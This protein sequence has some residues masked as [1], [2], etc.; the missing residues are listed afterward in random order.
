MIEEITAGW[1]KD[2]KYKETNQQRTFFKRVSSIGKQE[3]RAL[4]LYMIEQMVHLGYRTPTI[5][6]HT[7]DD[8]TCTTR[9]EWVEGTML[10]AALATMSHAQVY[11]LGLDAGMF[12][13]ALHQ[14]PVI[15]PHLE[16]KQTYSKKMAA[17]IDTYHAS[18]LKYEYD[19]FL[20]NTV[21]AFQHLIET[22]PVTYHHGDYHVGNMMYD[23]SGS[24]V[25]IDFDRCDT[26]DP[27]EEFNRIVWSVQAH[28][29]FASGIV[30][31]YFDAKPPHD[32]WCLLKLYISVNTL[33]SLPWAIPYGSEE[34]KTMK[35]QY[36]QVLEWYSDQ[37]TPIPSWY[38]TQ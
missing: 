13:K 15:H 32:F 7:S 38:Q 21:S 35:A 22:R 19:D 10:E 31:G 24:L 26:G 2:K 37:T 14:I 17:K 29:S 34:I 27:Y 1:S 20:F 12:L 23:T 36:A 30:D 11:Q 25:V 8:T 28:P 3:T 5:V 4:E 18:P 9:Y 16:W 6:S 33:S